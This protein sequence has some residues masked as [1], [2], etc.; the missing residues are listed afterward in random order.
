MQEQFMQ[1]FYSRFLQNFALAMSQQYS[2][3]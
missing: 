3:L 2:I 1:E